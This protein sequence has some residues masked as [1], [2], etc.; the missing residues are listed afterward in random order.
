MCCRILKRTR[1]QVQCYTQGHFVTNQGQMTEKYIDIGANLLDGMYR[2]EYHGKSYHEE[3]LSR[4]LERSW[5]VGMDKMIVT[6]GTLEEAQKAL[7]LVR[8]HEKLFTTVGVHPTRG[9][10]WALF[11]RGPEA[12]IEELE[13]VIQDGM[14]DG[15]VVAIGECGLDYDRTEFCDIEVQKACFKEHFKLSLKYNLPM[16]LHSRST[17]GD[18]AEILREFAGMMPRG[19]VV[20][21][22][23]GSLDDL[24]SLLGMDNIFIGING[25]SLKTDD[26]LCVAAQVPLDRLM[27][28][29]DA[30]WC[31]I[32]PTHASS[33]YVT[34]VITAKDKKK[35]DIGLQVKGRNEPCNIV[36]VCE[37]LARVTGISTQEIARRAHENTMK[38]FFDKE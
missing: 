35:H 1:F 2:G 10:E 28:E 38:V 29:T 27:L 12:Y 9:N 34:T 21:S 11:E 5:D 16:F 19:G 25:C 32:R 31:G 26:T 37:V 8:Q 36:Q 33:K 18:M 7:I 6:A 23:D 30:P 17:S 13:R 14:S 24:S 3:D 4:V 20:H 15:K 22:F